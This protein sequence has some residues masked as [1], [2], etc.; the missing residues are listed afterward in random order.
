MSKTEEQLGSIY[1]AKCRN[2]MYEIE[3]QMRTIYFVFGLFMGFVLTY[4]FF[5]LMR[6]IGL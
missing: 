6:I 2:L 5:M 4:I 1:L 3:K